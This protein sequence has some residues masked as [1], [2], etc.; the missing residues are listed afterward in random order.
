MAQAW[1]RTLS[2]SSLLADASP[3]AIVA[4]FI[5]V[6]V[7]CASTAVIVF[8]AARASGAGP[9]EIASWIWA[10]GVGCGVVGIILSLRYRQPIVAAWSTPGAALLA[11]TSGLSLSQA[12]WAFI[13]SG[14]LMLL[15][16]L[17]GWF[18]RAMSRLPV[19]LASGML[20]GV[21]LRFGMDVFVAMGANFGLVGAMFAAYLL[22]RRLWPRYAVLGVLVAGVA[23]A[24]LQGLLHLEAV[25]LQPAAPVWTAPAFSWDAMIGVALPLFVVTMASQNVPGVATLRACGYDAPVSP[26][27]SWTGA[28]TVILAPF[29]AYALNL[30]AITAAISAGPQAHE[31]PSRRYVA[32]VAA[33]V[34][35]LVMGASAAM[36]GA[37]LAA[38]PRELV[39]AV[40]GLALINTIGGGLAGAMREESDRE[41]ALVTFLVTASGT[42]LWGIG[43]AFWG[44]VA[45]GLTML[46]LRLRRSPRA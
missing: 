24:A 27:V 7:G 5:T 28:A 8:E 2:L 9:A 33:G 6:L 19:A 14:A 1:T 10:L 38:F 37:I 45:G 17:T 25:Q 26:L 3:S 21:L 41:P 11:T 15:C 40:A 4:G 23:V 39:I 22:G 12:T 16:G 29:G 32:A 46:A 13:A 31:D 36:L 34:F 35:Y 30:A 42:T 18:E 43:S 20:A 44:L